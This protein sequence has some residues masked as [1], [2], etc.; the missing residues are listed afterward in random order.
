MMDTSLNPLDADPY[1]PNGYGAQWYTNQDNLYEVFSLESLSFDA[2][3]TLA[4]ARCGTW[5]LIYAKFLHRP[6]RLACTGK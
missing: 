1:I 4:S 5:S 3:C 6:L 2:E